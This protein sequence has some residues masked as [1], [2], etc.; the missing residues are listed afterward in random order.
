M[1]A[2]LRIGIVIILIITGYFIG[3]QIAGNKKIKTNNSDFIITNK[4]HNFGEI[5]IDSISRHIYKYTNQGTENLIIREINPSCGCIR[6]NEFTDTIR[7]NDKGIIVIQFIPYSLG[8]F[9]KNIEVITNSTL[10]PKVNLT[11]K[12]FVQ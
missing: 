11:I 5:S 8:F 9:N 10:K 6:V 7:P 3:G 4:T 1:K 12:G 2:V